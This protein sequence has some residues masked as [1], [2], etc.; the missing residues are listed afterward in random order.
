MIDSNPSISP[1]ISSL[2]FQKNNYDFLSVLGVGGS[3]IV[4]KVKSL[5]Y[6]SMY[7]AAKVTPKTNGLNL[8]DF[9]AL[10]TLIHSYIISIFDYFE[11]EKNYYLILEYC[12]NGSLS[13]LIKSGQ[14]SSNEAMNFYMK[15]LTEVITFCHSKG[16][17]HRD[18]KC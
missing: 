16:I 10:K 1:L 13:S 2:P 3:S 7:F 12:E 5:N 9:N 4:F 17:A 11:D 18:I 14:L 8:Q 15:K 6:E